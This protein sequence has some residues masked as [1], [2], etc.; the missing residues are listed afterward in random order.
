MDAPGYPW[1]SRREQ[2]ATTFDPSILVGLIC[3]GQGPIVPESYYGA[4]RE[5]V[6]EFVRSGPE[7]WRGS[8]IWTLVATASAW[9][10]NCWNRSLCMRR[11]AVLNIYSVWSGVGFLV[12]ESAC[13]CSSTADHRLL[14]AVHA[15]LVCSGRQIPV[16]LGNMAG[17]ARTQRS[18]GR[19]AYRLEASKPLESRRD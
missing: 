19:R 13:N 7:E 5:T 16:R 9:G 4:E 14:A 8:C 11:C 1:D 12:M 6:A 10:K 17:R 3:K 18:A 15:I 2:G